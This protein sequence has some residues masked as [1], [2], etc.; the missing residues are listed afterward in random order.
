MKNTLS[1]SSFVLNLQV[2]FQ[3]AGN[4][5]TTGEKVM[6]Q[7]SDY[8]NPNGV[9]Y[10]AKTGWI[11]L[12]TPTLEAC[13]SGQVLTIVVSLLHTNGHAL[14]RISDLWIYAVSQKTGIMHTKQPGQTNR[15]CI[16]SHIGTGRG[17]RV[18][19]S[20][21]IVILIVMKLNY[22]LTAKA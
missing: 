13:S 16:F 8:G 7:T 22:S 4:I 5:R 19:A 17:K 21:C 11:L 6:F 12:N 10:P 1:E 15:R 9:H 18:I 3:R 20:K 2:S 14:H